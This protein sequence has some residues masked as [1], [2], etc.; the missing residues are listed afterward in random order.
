MMA[1]R[2]EPFSAPVAWLTLALT[3]AV[4]SA[5]MPIW[6]AASAE[7]SAWTRTAYLVDPATWTWA[8]PSMVESCRASRVSAYSSSL[9]GDSVCDDMAMNMIGQSAGFCLRNVGGCGMARGNWRVAA[10]IAACTSWAAASILRSRLN[11][12]VMVVLPWLLDEVIESMPLMVENWFS[13]GA[14]TALAMVS[15]SAPG[16]LALTVMVGKSKLGRSE[17][18]R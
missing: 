8:T 14:A 1:E 17:T 5:S 15:G 10:E 9:D 7:G 12:R 18:G 16:R 2:V 13:S 4:V 3:M 6:R 11:C